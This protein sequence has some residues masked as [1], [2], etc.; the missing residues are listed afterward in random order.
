MFTDVLLLAKG[1]LLFKG[2]PQSCI[3][4]A[5]SVR[6][7]TGQLAPSMGGRESES[8]HK[9]HLYSVTKTPWEYTVSRFVFS[10]PDNDRDAFLNPADAILDIVAAIPESEI[11]HVAGMGGRWAKAPRPV[12]IV[13][14][15]RPAL[16]TGSNF[17]MQGS[18]QGGGV[19]DLHNNS[20]SSSSSD[21]GS[22]SAKNAGL[23]LPRQTGQEGKQRRG[24]MQR[25]GSLTLGSDDATLESTQSDTTEAQTGRIG[26]VEQVSVVNARWWRRRPLF[27]KFWMLF[28]AIASTLI[29]GV[30]QRRVTDDLISLTLQIKGLILVSMGL[31]ALK[32][33]SIAMDYYDDR[34]VYNYDT[35][36]GSVHLV[37]FWVHRTVY[38]TATS[39]LESVA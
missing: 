5:Q 28:L 27:R 21:R 22:D 2:E 3:K 32:N 35:L 9:A 19:G 17:D 15:A 33:I 23:G 38:E 7:S 37:A 14:V 29:V 24:F 34:D 16:A 10:A 30:I 1:H 18:E 12:S 6:K 20:S 39:T 8:H 31:V 26:V 4:F 25:L 36:N 13:P 11:A